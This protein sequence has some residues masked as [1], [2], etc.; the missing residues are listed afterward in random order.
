MILFPYLNSKQNLVASLQIW[1]I[2][3][4]VPNKPNYCW[5]HRMIDHVFVLFLYF[6]PAPS[7][8]LLVLCYFFLFCWCYYF[9]CHFDYFF[10]ILI[11]FL[12][13]FSSSSLLFFVIFIIFY[14]LYYYF[15]I[16]FFCDPF[17]L[18]LL[19]IKY[20][21]LHLP[22]FPTSHIFL[23]TFLV[24]FC[25]DDNIHYSHIKKSLLQIQ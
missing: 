24:G 20:I 5:W 10:V 14:H 16:V 7:F 2:Q 22:T 25:F 3:L 8:F 23:L 15:F 6:F 9:F 21:L 1:T 13:S 12:S 11:I 4:A 19:R 17:L 18:L